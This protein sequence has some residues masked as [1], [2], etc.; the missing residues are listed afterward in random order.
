MEYPSS[1]VN[2]W[3]ATGFVRWYYKNEYKI[4]LDTAKAAKSVYSNLKCPVC[5]IPTPHFKEEKVCVKCSV[6]KLLEN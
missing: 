3:E 2:N 6:E 5:K 1:S 4:M